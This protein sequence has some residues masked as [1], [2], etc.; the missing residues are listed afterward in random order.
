[1][2]LTKKQIN[3]IMGAKFCVLATSDKNGNPRA[4]VV[5]PAGANGNK[6]VIA[7]V[8]MGKTRENILANKNVFVSFYDNEINGCI[9]CEGTATYANKG[10][11]FETVKN[12]LAEELAKDGL[13]VKGVVEVTISSVSEH[14]EG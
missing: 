11:L 12:D 7:D 10:E 6:V 5:L 14:K 3:F 1:M 4:C 8:Q 2:E 13:V 9:K